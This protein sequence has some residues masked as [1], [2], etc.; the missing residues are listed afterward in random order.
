MS[1]IEWVRANCRLLVVGLGG[2][3]LLAAGCGGGGAVRESGPIH[4]GVLSTMTGADTVVGEET[5]RGVQLASDSVNTAGGIR[6]RKLNVV[7]E[8]SKYSPENALLAARKLIDSDKASVIVNGTRSGVL[9]AWVGYAA[10]KGVVVIDASGSTGETRGLGKT[11]FS[12][13]ADA[14]VLGRELARWAFQNGHRRVA[15][16]V[17][18]NPAGGE[19]RKAAEDEFRRLGGQVVAAVEYAVGDLDHGP[20]V[21]QV[22]SQRPDAII[23][24]PYGSDGRILFRHADQ[25]GLKAPWYVAYPSQVVLD[26]PGRLA[27]RLYGLEVGYMTKN[28]Q[29]F[30]KAYSAKHSGQ[31]ATTWAAYSYDGVWVMA[32]AMRRAGVDPAEIARVFI[33][34]A[35]GFGGATGRI[36]FD[37][38]GHRINA[39]LERLMVTTRG[40]LEPA[41]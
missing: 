13:A 11:V 9:R 25:L 12:V 15:I 8:D 10:S 17:P 33:R 29:Q 32:S 5:V 30:R 26:N 14:V 6:T 20:T 19:L 7:V 39:P 1:M 3:V 18:S 37:D 36:E 35:A 40:E 23:A 31:A 21:R 24:S 34:S 41:P 28:A 16:A 27:G 2:L 38:D 22:A 4:I